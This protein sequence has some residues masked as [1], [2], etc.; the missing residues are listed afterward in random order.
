MILRATS[1]VPFELHSFRREDGAY[2][3]P[4]CGDIYRRLDNSMDLTVDDKILDVFH[5]I[6]NHQRK[7]MQIAAMD[8][9][10]L[11]YGDK[12][13]P[14]QRVAARW[15][16][17]V[18]RGILADEQGTG[19]TVVALAA[20]RI[21]NPKKVLI[22]C[23]SSKKQDWCDHVK[24]WIPGAMVTNLDGSPAD[25]M[26][27]IDWWEGYLVSN[28]AMA[29]VYMESL[30]KAD[31]VIVDEA[32]KVRN[33][34]TDVFKAIKKITKGDKPVYLLTASPTIN[35][36]GDIW[37]LLNI[38]DPKRFS[39]FWGFI[40]R[41]CY[42]EENQFSM[43]I[44]GV[45]K[46]EEDNLS[47]IIKPYTLMRRDLISL[48]ECEH[49]VYNYKMPQRQ[50]EL[51]ARMEQDGEVCGII[52]LSDLSLITRLRQLAL[53][54]GLFIDKYD[55][56]SKLDALIEIIQE[57]DSPVV[58]FTQ[59]ANL[60]M[61][62][63]EYLEYRGVK[64]V[65]LT[66]ALGQQNR[67]E[68]INRFKRGQVQ[69]IVTT[70]GTGGEG[71]NLMEADRVIFL[72]LAW[73]PAGNTHALKRIM[74]IGQKSNHLEAIYIKTEGTIEEEVLNIINNKEPVTIEKL[75]R[76]GIRVTKHTSK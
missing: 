9:T 31:L 2:S 62:A 16:V 59:F 47:K 70:H 43:K 18:K 15:L 13:F 25:R 66:G 12:L 36:A 53:H 57:R 17:N 22:I 55:G 20:A 49:R 34:A 48:P 4:I 7:V 44:R 69:V 45:K 10:N 60:V 21:I 28:Y 19:K 29:A 8:D 74:R 56:P 42:V 27:I 23:S 38:C 5:V 58:V 67:I 75:V 51:Y 61:L 72:D 1:Q 37:T 40:F 71:L 54:P 14:Y 6:S 46:G 30:S 76:S 68:V 35:I 50:A 3:F 64:A 26:H 41:F 33:K 11:Q 24:E 52:A 65:G 32:H 73:H 63:I 39:S